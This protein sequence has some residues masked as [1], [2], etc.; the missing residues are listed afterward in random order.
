MSHVDPAPPSASSAEPVPAFPV[1]GIGASAGGLAA[2]T[3]FF[4]GF[5]DDRS[6]GMA[7]ILV[8]HLPADADSMLTELISRTTRMPVSKAAPGMEVVPDHVYIMPPNRELTFNQGRLSLHELADQRVRLPIDRLFNSLAQALGKR[9]IGVVM[10]GTGCDGTQGSRAIRAG[11]GLVIAQSPKSCEFPGMP[12]SAIA[13]GVVDHQAAPADLPALLCAIAGKSDRL[14]SEPVQPVPDEAARRELITL[15]RVHTGH[16]FSHYKRNTILRRVER[17]LAVHQIT[18]LADY[19]R[20]VEQTPNELQTLFRDVLIGVTSFFRDPESFTVLDQQVIP[21]LLEHRPAA[22]R[23]W[24]AGCSTGEEAYSLA[25]LIEEHLQALRWP[26]QV[27]VFATDLDPQAIADARTGLYPASIAADVTPQRL[28]RWFTAESAGYRINRTIRDRLVFSEHDLIKDP[29]F[30]RLDLLCCRNLLIYLDG[31]MQRKLLPLFHNAVKP[32]GWLFLGPSESISDFTH[33]FQVEDRAARLYRN[34]EHQRSSALPT[35]NRLLP[36]MMPP[37]HQSFHPASS[38]RSLREVTE[39]ALLTQIAPAAALVNRCGDLLYLHGRTGMFLEPAPGEAGISNILKMAREGLRHPLMSAIRQATLHDQP[40]HSSGVRVKTNGHFTLIDLTVCPVSGP[41]NAVAETSPEAGALLVVF[42]ET[43]GSRPGSGVLPGPGAA[44]AIATEPAHDSGDPG[45]GPDQTV[46]ALTRALHD[47]EEYLHAA[48]EALA[49]TNDDLRSANEELQS[50]NEELQ[51]ANEELVTAKEELQSVNEEL[52]TVNGE[53]Q[54]K[55]A[56][57]SRANNDLNNLLAGTGIATLFLDLDQRILRFTATITRI[58]HLIPS[59][60]GR[61]ISDLVTK[62]SGYQQFSADIQAVLDT[63]VPK[64]LE[65]ATADG[66]WFMMRIL[67]YRTLDNVIEG[68]VVTFVDITEAKRIETAQRRSESLLR[69][70][71]QA[72]AL[73]SWEWDVA[74]QQAWWSDE[75]FRLHDLDPAAIHPT[76]MGLLLRSLECLAPDDRAAVRAALLRCIDAGVPYDLETDF[77]TAKGRTLRV[78]ICAEPVI[79]RGQVKKVVGFIMDRGPD[80]MAS[81]TRREQPQ[82]SRGNGDGAIR[83][84]AG[85][86][87]SSVG[88]GAA[89]P[90]SA[91]LPEQS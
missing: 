86:G 68:A 12:A 33:L 91:T 57:L 17:R 55:V 23:I 73:G 90:S 19:V 5:P 62:L 1:V 4:Q 18:A 72:N 83:E 2:F 26:C 14:R 16:D 41:R 42:R 39:K 37:A 80:Q 29:P 25:I 7:F 87:P 82:A 78:R 47:K 27:T 60:L 48:N 52:S 10:T 63:L 34:A 20:F 40:V 75:T 3:E 88:D 21:K 67:P 71:Q 85:P 32:G 43:A 61:P 8:Q 66:R 89:G 11:D 35:L 22:L 45:S 9:A 49:S 46:T 53:L 24:S 64:E 70:I 56:E 28:A 74:Q 50:V 79:D 31:E 30:T 13:A 6:L 84:R 59:D 65:V 77:V 58:I 15:L 44:E 54:A 76:G 38:P 81:A 36:T 51:S 69:M